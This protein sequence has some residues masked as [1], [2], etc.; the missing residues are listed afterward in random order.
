MI[1]RPLAYHRPPHD[2]FTFFTP[3]LPNATIVDYPVRRWS[4]VTPGHR[5]GITLRVRL[6]LCTLLLLCGTSCAQLAGAGDDTQLT[7][8]VARFPACDAEI[9][10]FVALTKLAKQLG[11]DWQIYEPA[12]EALQDQILDCVDDNYPDPVPI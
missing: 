8:S 6:S 4:F 7:G 12:L 5:E 2:C 11:D 3:R 9:K 10:A 1:A